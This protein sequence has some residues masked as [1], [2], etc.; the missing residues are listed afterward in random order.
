MVEKGFSKD[1]GPVAV[2]LMEHV[3]GRRLVGEIE[4]HLELIKTDDSLK[5]KLARTIRDYVFLLRN[6]I[7]KENDILFTM[8]EQAL[9]KEDLENLS[10]EFDKV[11]ANEGGAA[12]HEKYYKLAYELAGK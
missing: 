2:M 4:K 9:N 8:A 5:P 11:E 12:V 1:A 6:H 3:E 10:I 7:S